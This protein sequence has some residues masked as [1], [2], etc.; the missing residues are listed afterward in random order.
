MKNPNLIIG[1]DPGTGV[2]SPTGLAVINPRT[3]QLVHFETLTSQQRDSARKIKDISE[4]L[5]DVLLS[6]DSQT[7]IQIYIESFVMQ[8]RSG[9]VLA[10]LTGALMA[11]V[12]YWQ[13]LNFISNMTVKKLVGGH[14]HADKVVVAD[15]V[16]KWLEPDSALT[17]KRLV[18]VN[19]FDITDA[20]AIAIAGHISY[21]N[22]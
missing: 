22:D 9:E 5:A 14:G 18:D 13:Q 15:G 8:G 16:A 10:R 1:I 3:R 7:R 21:G 19:E 20:A 6:Y 11:A 4:Q 2:S 12:P 17:I